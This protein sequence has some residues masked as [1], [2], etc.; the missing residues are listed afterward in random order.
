MP[1]LVFKSN[2][3]QYFSTV[4]TEPA[5]VNGYFVNKG[6]D[7][8]AG[9]GEGFGDM[10]LIFIFTRPRRSSDKQ[11]LYFLIAVRRS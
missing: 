4:A 3:G 6:C 10:P 5:T 9:A 1:F 11:R 2:Q 7:G 8:A